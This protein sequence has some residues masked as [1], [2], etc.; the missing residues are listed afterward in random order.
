MSSSSGGDSEG[1]DLDFFGVVASALRHARVVLGIPL[2]LVL[3]VGALVL[4]GRRR[5]SVDVVFMP[6]SQGGAASQ[7]VGLAA[8]F[9]LA[10]AAGGDATDSPDFYSDFVRSDQLLASVATATYR[11]RVGGRDTT[12][13]LMIPLGIAK[14]RPELMRAN[15]IAK[16]RSHVSVSVSPKTGTVDLSVWTWDPDLSMQIVQQMLDEVNRFNRQVRQNQAGQERR[17]IGTR[18]DSALAD[19][20]TAQ[21]R[22]Q[23]FLQRN[24]DF[25]NSPSLQFEH[26]RILQDVTTQ[27]GLYT[28]LLQNYEQARIEEVRTTPVITVVEQPIRPARPDSRKLVIRSFLVGVFGLLIG[29]VAA[30]GLDGIERRRSEAPADAEM[31]RSLWVARKS[32]VAALWRR[33][34]GRTT[35][36]DGV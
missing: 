34:R 7:L 23:A 28:S 31:V 25:A 32:E 29:I 10:G 27:L 2:A 1:T 14:T 16:L 5:Y 20:R 13:D 6:S 18:V 24:R 17:F 15:A 4:L 3:V 19:L 12:G 36:P 8:Q 11:F 33:L 26:D 30:L 9:G 22:M 21:D 35:G